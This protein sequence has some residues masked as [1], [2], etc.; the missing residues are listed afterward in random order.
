MS[1]P[2]QWIERAK[3]DLETARAMLQAER[4]LYVVFCCQQAVEKALK[5]LIVVRSGGTPPRLHNLVRLAERAGLRLD[6][7]RTEQLTRLSSYYIPARY[8]GE[9]PAPSSAADEALAEEALQATEGIVEWL[10][11]LM[12]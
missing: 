8:P 9:M 12:T 5:A 2:E 3:Y 4:Y 6:E 1:A 11:N 7:T 10:L